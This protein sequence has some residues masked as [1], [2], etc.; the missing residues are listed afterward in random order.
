PVPSANKR[1]HSRPLPPW[2]LGAGVYTPPRIRGVRD[3]RFVR[4]FELVEWKSVST[5][6][7]DS[8]FDHP[9]HRRREM[10]HSKSG[11]FEERITSPLPIFASLSLLQRTRRMSP[12]MAV[13]RTLEVREDRGRNSARSPGLFYFVALSQLGIVLYA[14]YELQ[15]GVNI[16]APRWI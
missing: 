15:H 13:S 6:E 7:C 4:P 12:F 3:R 5:S 11:F 2:I 16:F 9:L 14:L 8:P 10:G 1:T